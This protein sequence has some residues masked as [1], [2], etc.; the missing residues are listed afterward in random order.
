MSQAGQEALPLAQDGRAEVIQ[1]DV[2][3]VVAGEPHG[4]AVE[5][6]AIGGLGVGRSFRLNE[7]LHVPLDRV[8]PAGW[9][10]MPRVSHDFRPDY[11]F[12]FRGVNGGVTR[13]MTPFWGGIL[14]G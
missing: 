4:E 13:P 7:R 10:V 2:G 14:D 8:T 1:G 12:S 5:V 6:L 3:L 9:G 11:A